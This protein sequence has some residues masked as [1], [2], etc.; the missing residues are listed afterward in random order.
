MQLISRKR[1]GLSGRNQ[2][3][4]P[5]HFAEM[6]FILFCSIYLFIWVFGVFFILFIY[7]FIIIFFFGLLVWVYFILFLFL[8]FFFFFA[9]YSEIIHVL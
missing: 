7:L 6:S 4:Y 5:C 8:I 2:S 9:G 1:L 3:L